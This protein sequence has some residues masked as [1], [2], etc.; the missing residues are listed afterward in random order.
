MAC[1]PTIVREMVRV[2]AGPLIVIAGPAS[3]FTEVVG[4]IV[5]GAPFLVFIPSGPGKPSIEQ[6]LVGYT[7]STARTSPGGRLVNLRKLAFPVSVLVAAMAPVG[8]ADIPML[9]PSPMVP[10]EGRGLPST[11]CTDGNWDSCRL[12]APPL[13]SIEIVARLL[14]LLPICTASGM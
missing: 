6:T 12:Q 4:I 2:P 11:A 7:T 9:R 13:G 8:R 5:T 3:R 14:T 1:P 10:T